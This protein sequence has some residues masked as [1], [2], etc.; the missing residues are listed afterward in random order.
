MHHLT[1]AYRPLQGVSM[2][3]G[4][5]SVLCSLLG[6]L[7]G[8]EQCLGH[9][10]CLASTWHVAAVSVGASCPPSSLPNAP[11]PQ[12]HRPS[13]VLL[14]CHHLPLSGIILAISLFPHSCLSPS[15]GQAKVRPRLPCSTPLFLCPAQ[16]WHGQVL[17][18]YLWNGQRKKGKEAGKK[19][20]AHL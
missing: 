11:Q 5:M 9:G 13:A 1:N 8:L 19:E 2:S 7:Q 16:R 20:G 6:R 4:T 14:P 15:S 17:R 3:P 18:G 12:R 10:R